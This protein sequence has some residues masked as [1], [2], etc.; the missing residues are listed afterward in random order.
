[1]AIS[2]ETQLRLS[3]AV[4][5][6]RNGGSGGNRGRL[7]ACYD[8]GKAFVGTLGTPTSCQLTYSANR[9]ARSSAFGSIRPYLG[10]VGMLLPRA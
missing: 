6:E 1:V 3:S 10:G 9:L 8:L 4:P 5:V 2:V 7:V